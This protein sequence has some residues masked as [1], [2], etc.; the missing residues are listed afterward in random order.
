VRIRHVRS[1][2]RRA[3][4]V[5]I[6]MLL[7]GTGLA[8]GPDP[9]RSATSSSPTLSLVSSR[10]VVPPPAHE[11]FG[12]GGVG[13]PSALR[14]PSLSVLSPSVPSVAR[15]P[16][17]RL[18]DQVTSATVSGLVVGNLDGFGPSPILADVEVVAYNTSCSASPRL[19]VRVQCLVPRQRTRRV[20]IR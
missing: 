2:C 8:L 20:S 9:D 10:A 7:V 18:G 3:L 4:V 16:S 11:P 5:G 12:A 13:T 17:Q 19:R 14:E 1:P 15:M 6:A